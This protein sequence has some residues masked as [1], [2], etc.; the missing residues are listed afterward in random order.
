M[1]NSHVVAIYHVRCSETQG[2]NPVSYIGE[3]S[4]FRLAGMLDSRSKGGAT[5]VVIQDNDDNR[6]HI[7]ISVCS[8]KDSFCRKD[9]VELA[10][11]RAE[12]AL[13]SKVLINGPQIERYKLVSEMLLKAAINSIPAKY[14]VSVI[15]V[16]HVDKKKKVR[17]QWARNEDGVYSPVDAVHA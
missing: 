17:R 12:A 5:V 10:K 16:P 2:E 1:S 4:T 3:R 11:L 9:G 15:E 14:L 13:E 8:P 6:Y 7:G